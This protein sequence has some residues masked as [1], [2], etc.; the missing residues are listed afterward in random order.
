MSWCQCCGLGTKRSGLQVKPG[1][2]HRRPRA[3]PGGSLACPVLSTERTRIWHKFNLKSCRPGLFKFSL[4]VRRRLILSESYKCPGPESSRFQMTFKLEGEVKIHL[5][6]FQVVRPPKYDHDGKGDD[7]KF[8]LVMS[9][10]ELER[11]SRIIM[12]ECL[13][14]VISNLKVGSAYSAYS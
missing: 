10:Y 9:R 2:E 4:P 11:T 5:Q 8:N 13:V 1:P 12:I 14:Q 7:C 6:V 3:G